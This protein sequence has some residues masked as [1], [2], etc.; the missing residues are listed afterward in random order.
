[1]NTSTANFITDRLNYIQGNYDYDGYV[2]TGTNNLD[3]Y[4]AGQWTNKLYSLCSGEK[5]FT[6]V[7]LFYNSGENKFV[8]YY[9]EATKYTPDEINNI[10]STYKYML[11]ENNRYWVAGN[12]PNVTWTNELSAATIF[13]TS[14]EA[15]A[16]RQSFTSN[17]PKVGITDANKTGV[18]TTIGNYNMNATMFSS[19]EDASAM[20]TKM[21]ETTGSEGNYHP[22]VYTNGH[23]SYNTKYFTNIKSNSTTSSV[24]MS[25]IPLVKLLSLN[26]FIR[27]V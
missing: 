9:S 15:E 18:Y 11:Y 2:Y 1:M 16:V 10:L 12:Q 7:V 20:V 22:S 8:R 5:P 21:Y 6:D 4:V 3:E 19:Y 23:E 26:Y 14:A 17:A 25:D 13:D 27:P 24:N